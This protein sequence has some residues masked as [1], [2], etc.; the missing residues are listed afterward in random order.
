M[1]GSVVLLAEGGVV[2][3]GGAG[4]GRRDECWIW[5][6]ETPTLICREVFVALRLG[7]E[8]EGAEPERE[9]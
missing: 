7:R 8:E 5:L 6:L 2:G 3:E 4:A 9:I 1:V